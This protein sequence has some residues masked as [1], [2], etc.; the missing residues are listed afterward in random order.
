MYRQIIGSLCIQ[1]K[2]ILDPVYDLKIFD[3]SRS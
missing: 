2:P 1:N 3:F